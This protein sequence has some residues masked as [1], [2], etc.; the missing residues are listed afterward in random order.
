MTTTITAQNACALRLFK[1]LTALIFL[2]TI[3]PHVLLAQSGWTRSFPLPRDRFK[4]GNGT[5]QAFSSL[6][7]TVR[8]SV[9][10]LRREGE[11][12]ALGTV[13]DKVGLILT[14]ASEV[15][16]GK[17]TCRL[18]SGEETSGAIIGIDEENDVALVEIC[19]AVE[20]Q[21]IKWSVEPASLG[22]WTMTPGLE[23]KPE[24]V[25]ILSAP[26]R[27]IPP[28]RALIGIQ[29]DF[30]SATAARIGKV[31]A[32][33]GAEKAGLKAGDL[34]L[35]LNDAPV[36]NGEGLIN[37]LRTFKQGQSVKLRVRR[38]EEEFE[39][40]IKLAVP[41]REMLDVPLARSE[42]LNRFGSEVSQRSE[43]FNLVLQH[44]TVLQSWQCG[45]PLV[46]LSGK[47]IGMNIARAGRVA[48]YALPSELVQEIIAQLKTQRQFSV[49]DEKSR[50]S[51]R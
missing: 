37:D 12:V 40:E 27:K 39:T 35:M 47:A 9:V 18:A 50:T 51:F 42:E 7:A 4:N 6:A 36:R 8:E 23:K 26:V 19:V 33:L 24:A 29:L 46:D 2:L 20:L 28:P 49:K 34:I 43:G 44:D 48:S 25:G 13:V 15:K 1:A 38:D 32:G 45:G 17:L 5:L 10:E 14:K 11:L 31:M 3:S 21:P 22:Q 16:D 30:R 41:T